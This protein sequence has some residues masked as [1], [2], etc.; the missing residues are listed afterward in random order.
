VLDWCGS[1]YSGRPNPPNL[2]FLLLL[3]ELLRR[4]VVISLLLLF[5]SNLLFEKLSLLASLTGAKRDVLRHRKFFGRFDCDFD[6]FVESCF[7]RGCF[8]SCCYRQL[9]L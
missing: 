8:K 5:F 2:F 7:H 6:V 9:F 3:K 4:K 1:K